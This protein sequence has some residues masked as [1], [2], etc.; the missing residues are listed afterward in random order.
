MNKQY[1]SSISY[2]RS[3]SVISNLGAPLIYFSITSVKL[4]LGG[5]S[6]ILFF[7]LHRF[8]VCCC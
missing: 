2:F 8:W 5:A 3:T 4:Y 7:F 1:D 6:L